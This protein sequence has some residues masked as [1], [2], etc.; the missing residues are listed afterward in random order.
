MDYVSLIQI[1]LTPC[2]LGYLVQ[3]TTYLNYCVPLITVKRVDFGYQMYRDYLVF[4]QFTCFVVGFFVGKQT[5]VE[6]KN[7]MI[8]EKQT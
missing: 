2:C 3:F 1:K 6:N 7:Q 8:L 5:F 4:S